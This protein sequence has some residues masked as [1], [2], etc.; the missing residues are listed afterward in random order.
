MAHAGRAYPI[1]KYRPINGDAP[2]PYWAADVYRFQLPAATGTLADYL[3]EK[4]YFSAPGV[5]TPTGTLYTASQ[6]WPLI[7]TEFFFD[8]LIGWTN[9]DPDPRRLYFRIE[10][11]VFPLGL[12]P[13]VYDVALYDFQWDNITPLHEFT[14]PLTPR[15]PP[16][17]WLPFESCKIRAKT[18]H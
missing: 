5:N 6:Y 14:L 15:V 8:F 17:D 4:V 13:Y 1:S 9:A 2:Y 3:S 12:P 18:W 16:G 7:L 11:K 10:A